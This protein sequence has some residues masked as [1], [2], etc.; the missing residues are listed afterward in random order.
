ME[1]GLTGSHRSA[2]SADARTA[3]HR[4]C[5]VIALAMTALSLW[6]IFS[7]VPLEPDFVA[8]QAGT[9][10][11]TV[12]FLVGLVYLVLR[13]GCGGS[14][15]YWSGA[16]GSGQV[17]RIGI[18]VIVALALQMSI[19][20]VL[21]ATGRLDRVTSSLVALVVWISVPATFLALRIVK[22]PTRLGRASRAALLLTA[23]LGIS[24]AC[25]L[26]YNSFDLS[27][28]VFKAGSFGEASL[29]VGEVL[30]AAV[31]EE[32]VFRV[33]LLTALLDLAATRF[34]AVFLSGVAFAAV[35]APLAVIQPL[36]RADWPML[37]YA[38]YI[39]APEFSLQAVAGFVLGVLWLRTG[40]ITLVILTHALLNLGTALGQGWL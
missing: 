20:A 21:D 6:A 28:G 18:M 14:A 2:L 1:T 8:V 29:L 9:L 38:A 36:I 33:L 25:L 10:V 27:G 40:S 34:Q 31:P 26:S 24:F 4:L 11:L 3:V 7:R 16:T 30:V 35:H 15:V 19:G 12:L 13:I 37:Q 32:I 17:W 5:Q 22:W 23:L 39:Y